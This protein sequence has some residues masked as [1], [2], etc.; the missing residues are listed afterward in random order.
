MI[1]VLYRS[2]SSACFEIEGASPHYAPEPY[3]VY[4]DGVER[5]SGAA[6]VFSLFGLEPDST[7]KVELRYA[8]GKTDAVEFHTAG[9]TCCLTVRDF[10]AVGDGVHEDTASLQA[11]INAVTAEGSCSPPAHT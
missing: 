7:Y 10:G 5:Q 1:D 11:A 6:N 4:V 3:Q 9:E 2:G 8:S